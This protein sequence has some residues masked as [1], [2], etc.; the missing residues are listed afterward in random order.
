[1]LQCKIRLKNQGALLLQDKTAICE[2]L[3]A[4]PKSIPTNH[5]AIVEVI[6]RRTLFPSNVLVARNV[7][8]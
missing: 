6:C 1:M 2:L 3:V 8:S 4:Y 5:Q 7:A